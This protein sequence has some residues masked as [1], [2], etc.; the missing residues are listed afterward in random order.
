[1][2]KLLSIIVIAA[3]CIGT[4]FAQDVAAQESKVASQNVEG[5]NDKA[6]N[7]M[8]LSE[9]QQCLVPIAAFEA[10]GDL[11]G[12][13]RAI[14]EGLEKGLTVAEMN[15]AL[16]QLYAYMGF[17]RALNA[18]GV[19]Q[20]VVGDRMAAG[21]AVPEG[22]GT[23]V[24]P[25]DF[26]ALK[27]GT[28]VQTKLSGRPFDY[29]FSP[30]LD[31][32]LKAH[33]FGDIFAGDAL[34]QSDREI[35]TVSAI[36]ALAGCEPQLGAHLK[37]ALNMGVTLGQLREI[38]AVLEAKV[39]NVEAY[40]VRKCLAL[41]QGEPFNEGE[42]VDFNVWPRGEFNAAYAKYFVGNSYLASL[43]AEHGGPVNVTFEPGCRN[44]WH[45]HHNSVQVLICVS[46]RGWYQE[47]G[48]Q[49]VEMK[50]GTV[51]AITAE[52][53][54]WHGAAKDSWFQHLTYVTAAGPDAS[55][56]WL[57]PVSDE[58]YGSLR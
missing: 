43:D 33:L 11:V 7:I 58:V 54:H 39:G 32:Y 45:I 9:R 47:W 13:G 49:P 37:G 38:P 4:S 3:C 51:I 8:E 24:L 34:S 23:Y 14:N 12:L 1:M 26:D 41:N 19:L 53:K 18:T 16:S 5:Q 27:T 55:T 17:P 20:K 48:K 35:V 29:K 31:Y 44:N 21:K 46:G 52:A 36:S 15:E 10:K 6:H 57:E 42:P 2:K 28:A 22:K 30:R 25:A 40:R 50:P 56:E